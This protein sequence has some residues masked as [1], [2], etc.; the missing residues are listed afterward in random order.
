MKQSITD[1]I[2]EYII[3]MIFKLYM[4]VDTNYHV[5]YLKKIIGRSYMFLSKIK[6]L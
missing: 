6:I 4:N 1:I 5:C 2:I 3:L